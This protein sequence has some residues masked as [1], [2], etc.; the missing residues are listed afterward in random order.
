[1]RNQDVWTIEK[2]LSWM[3]SFFSRKKIAEPRL[4]AEVLIAHAVQKDRLYLYTHFDTPL[5]RAELNI[6]RDA[7]HKR[8]AGICVAYI[9][10]TK[11]FMGLPFHVDERVLVP[12]SDTELLVDTVLQARKEEKLRIGDV[13]VGSGAIL[14]SVLHY[15]PQWSGIAVDISESALQ[16]AKQNALQLA[17]D[18]RCIY[19][20]GDFLEPL[21]GVELDILVS[22][23]PYIP[24]DDINKL[25]IEVRKEPRMALDGGT[26]GLDFYR[27]LV[28]DAKRCV[29]AGGLIAVE[30]GHDQAADVVALIKSVPEYTEPKVYSDLGGHDRVIA[31]E[32]KR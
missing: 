10:G 4:D 22:N 9:I 11:E 15:R 5:S 31:W 29:V 23:P 16:V 7:V 32:V 18:E 17:L 19:H 13:G 20:C 12:R 3:T 14:L 21:Y 24:S 25:T 28:S 27:R 2:M 30:I 26:D 1:M 8:A 6:L